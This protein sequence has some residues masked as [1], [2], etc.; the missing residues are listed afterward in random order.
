M[1]MNMTTFYASLHLGFNGVDGA[2]TTTDESSSGKTM[3]F[4]GDAALETSNAMFG[5]ASLFKS[6]T[7]YVHTPDHADFDFTGE[8]T[9]EMWLAVGNTSGGTLLSKW[10]V[11]GNQRSWEIGVTDG[12]TYCTVYFAISTDGTGSGGNFLNLANTTVGFRLPDDDF[13]TKHHI[14][15]TRNSSNLVRLFVDGVMAASGTLS[16]TTFS[17]T[18]KCCV[19][20]RDDGSNDGTQKMIDEVRITKGV[21]RY[22]SNTSFTPP[23]AAFPRS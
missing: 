17:T 14:M 7:G 18:T 4:A 5:S 16:G 21:C 22:D 8:F 20:A 9:L 3:T 6:T 10:L 12:G 23:T 19:L 13:A 1:P 2:T 15:V 11:T